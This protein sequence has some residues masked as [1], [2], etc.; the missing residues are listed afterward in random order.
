MLCYAMQGRG[1]TRT[2]A[3]AYSHSQPVQCIT[4][5]SFLRQKREKKIQARTHANGQKNKWKG[6]E[7]GG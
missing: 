1:R 3:Q 6:I 5:N 7:E 2:R 4:M